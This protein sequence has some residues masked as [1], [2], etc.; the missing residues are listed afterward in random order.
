MADIKSTTGAERPIE[1]VSSNVVAAV[2]TA[3]DVDPIDLPPLYG[4]IDPDAL[5]RLFRSMGPGIES[6]VARVSFT[7]AACE[8]VVYGPDHVTVTPDGSDSESGSEE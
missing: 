1:A 3:K 7:F 5:E 4:A 8:V 6:A 2:A